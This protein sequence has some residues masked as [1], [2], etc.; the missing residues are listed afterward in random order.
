MIKLRLTGSY[1]VVEPRDCGSRFIK[2]FL[3]L[4]VRII[5]REKKNLGGFQYVKK[6]QVGGIFF[7]L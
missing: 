5:T 1:K 3:L 2:A 6:W 7:L 4:G